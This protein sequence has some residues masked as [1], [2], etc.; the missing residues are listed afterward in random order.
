MW[1]DHFT[2]VS[3]DAPTMI[4]ALPQYTA[5]CR[6]LC[7]EMRHISL[8]ETLK[9]LWT[10]WDAGIGDATC[11]FVFNFANILRILLGRAYSGT[12][13]LRSAAEAHSS[14]GLYR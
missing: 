12:V 9:N 10:Q 6:V 3:S 13:T 8:S 14:F 4:W 7:L 5:I 11:A 2:D 1:C